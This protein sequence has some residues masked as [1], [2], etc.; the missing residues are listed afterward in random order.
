MY[1]S[2]TVCLSRSCLASFRCPA[3]AACVCVSRSF[4][5]LFV[6]RTEGIP[7]FICKN[8]ML[9]LHGCFMPVFGPLPTRYRVAFPSRSCNLT[10]KLLPCF[11]MGSLCP[12]LALYGPAPVEFDPFVKP[13][14]PCTVTI[15][16]LALPMTCTRY[17]VCLLYTSPSPRDLST[18]RMP[19]SA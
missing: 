16:V 15:S 11:M 18:S 2:L 13:H 9:K 17:Q 10:P 1:D 5:A 14:Q 12:V 4:S 6:C 3:V 19:S 7:V 8:R